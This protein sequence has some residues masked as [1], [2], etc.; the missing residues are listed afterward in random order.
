MSKHHQANRRRTYGRRQHEI[1]ERR[2][3]VWPD[4]AV[5][6]HPIADGFAP[7]ERAVADQVGQSYR[8]IWLGLE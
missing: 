5:E 6:G 4:G 7:V 2:D 1:R 3:R 8:A